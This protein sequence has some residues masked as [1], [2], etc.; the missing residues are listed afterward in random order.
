M[1]TI[2][3]NNLF[4]NAIKYNFEEGGMI[5][6]MLDDNSLTIENTSP[7]E[8]IDKQFIFERFKKNSTS[9]SLGVGLSLIKKV[10]DFFNWQITYSHKDKLHRFKIYM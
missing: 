1:L 6:I 10:V 3:L 8:K 7:V 9:G 2:L 4:I 5:R